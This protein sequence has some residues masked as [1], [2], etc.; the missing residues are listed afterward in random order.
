MVPTLDPMTSPV[1]VIW[2]DGHTCI[3]G[4]WIEAPTDL[5][6]ELRQ[7]D[8]GEVPLQEHD[9]GD[10]EVEE[11]DVISDQTLSQNLIETLWGPDVTSYEPEIVAFVSSSSHC[12]NFGT[13][14]CHLS[15]TKVIKMIR[16]KV[17][18]VLYRWR[19]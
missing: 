19:Q 15:I 16:A 13:I 8:N 18:Q 10:Q 12:H 4:P 3:I 6:V 11:A 9:V 7:S 2:P 1:K 14:F 5:V 17:C